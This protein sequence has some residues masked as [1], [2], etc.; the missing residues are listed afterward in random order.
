MLRATIQGL[1]DIHILAT[2]ADQRSCFVFA[3]CRLSL[4]VCAQGD[5]ELCADLFT[6]VVT[7]I[8]RKEGG[9]FSLVHDLSPPFFLRPT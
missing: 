1:N 2:Y 4:F 3:V 5:T 7:G 6:E 9:D 8:E